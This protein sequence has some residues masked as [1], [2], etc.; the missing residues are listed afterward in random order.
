M[1]R[2]VQ[3][4]SSFWP[5]QVEETTYHLR[6]KGCQVERVWHAVPNV[7]RD[8]LGW[9]CLLDIPGRC[10]GERHLSLEF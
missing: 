1:M 7:S 5:E 8:V 3:D 9:R 2:R 6:W 10:Q 4:G